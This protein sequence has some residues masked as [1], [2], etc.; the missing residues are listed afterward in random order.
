[1]NSE[2]TT[3]TTTEKNLFPKA[4]LRED[5]NAGTV[6]VEQERATAEAQGK[7]VLAKRFPR[8]EQRAY[9]KIME[10][11]QRLGF[12]E[13]AAFNYKR[14]GSKVS[15]PTIRLAEELARCWGNIDFGL[16][17]LSQ[18]PGFS[19][20]EAWAW[21]V[22][23]NTVSRQAFTVAHLRDKQGGATAL[24]TERDKYEITANMGARRLRA[25]IMAILPPDLIDAAIAA[26][27]NTV[28]TGGTDAPPL[29]DRVRTMIG[30]FSTIGVTIEMIEHY[31]GHPS[32]QMLPEEF[33]DLHGIFQSVKGGHAEAG[34]YFGIEKGGAEKQLESL[35][36]ET[37]AKTATTEK[38]TPAEKKPEPK[39]KVEKVKE[40]TVEK[41]KPP[42][43]TEEP[44]DSVMD[45]NIPP[46]S[47][48]HGDA[49]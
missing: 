32:G 18:R 21:D 28:K 5:V 20:M 37:T 26:C 8:D 43:S 38:K 35:A 10:S 13:S 49:F 16:R 29:A 14:G 33:A 36:L 40:K 23:T 17:E 24:T 6:A 44:S 45:R 1:M 3:I 30:R 39:P 25:R 27:A 7:M 9:M 15:G 34:D 11:C 47:D 12:A 42:A 41:K 2:V 31:L 48:E 4:D 19:E 46:P 22:E